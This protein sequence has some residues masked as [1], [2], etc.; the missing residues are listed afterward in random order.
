MVRGGGT[1][2]P[3]SLRTSGPKP[4]ASTNFATRASKK[5]KT[6]KLLLCSLNGYKPALKIG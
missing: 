4:G 3:T 6:S 5:P 2:T 1:R